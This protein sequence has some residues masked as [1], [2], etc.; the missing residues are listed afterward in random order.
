MFDH[1]EVF[2]TNFHFMR[3]WWLLSIIPLVWFYRSVAAK[4][5]IVQQWRGHM[6]DKLISHLSRSDKQSVNITP[7]TL[8]LVFSIIATVVMAGPSWK[9]T[10][11]PFFVNESALIIALD[12]SSSMNTAD[13]QPSRL[14]RAK[15]KVNELIELRG[16]AKTALIVYAGS[17]HVA[18][19]VTKDK[20]MIKHFLDVLDSSLMPVKESDPESVLT[21]AKTVLNQTKAP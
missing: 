11:S 12:V 16:D 9:Q 3:P 13:I 7:K 6:S 10:A 8:F 17:A 21:P 5:D 2:I 18:M 14:L 4:D 20:A 19:P 15:Q 1:I